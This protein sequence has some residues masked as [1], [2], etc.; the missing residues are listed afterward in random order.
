MES[1]F[2]GQQMSPGAAFGDA[3]A[4]PGYLEASGHARRVPP[5]GPGNPDLSAGLAPPDPQNL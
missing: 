3:R 4:A 2:G 1:F 5:E